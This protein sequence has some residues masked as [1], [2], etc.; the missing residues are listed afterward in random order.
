MNAGRF[1]SSPVLNR[2][3][4]LWLSSFPFSARNKIVEDLSENRTRDPVLY[5]F[6]ILLL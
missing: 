5:Y 1:E 6:H 2:T 3:V 4:C